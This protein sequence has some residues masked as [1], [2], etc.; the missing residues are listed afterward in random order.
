VKVLENND[1]QLSRVLHARALANEKL[2]AHAI[3]R[4]VICDQ[5]VMKSSLRRGQWVLVRNESPQ[6]FQSKWFGP[7]QIVKA[8]PLGM[9]ALREPGG[10]ELK[11]LVNGQ[12]LVKA[13]VRD[14]P[15]HL[16][17]STALNR[18][19]QD[20]GLSIEKPV[21]V[22][23]VLDETEAPPLS[24]RELSQMTKAE[25][26][27]RKHSGE[28]LGQ[29]GEG[30]LANQRRRSNKAQ[31]SGWKTAAGT[32]RPGRCIK[33]S[34]SKQEAGSKK[35]STVLDDKMWEGI[36]GNKKEKSTTQRDARELD[37]E[38][39]FAVVIPSHQEK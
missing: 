14:D 25:W 22:R 5:Q 37:F 17:T 10:Y 1:E 35:D 38:G 31:H 15:T 39:P 21:K 26:D 33:E 11:N 7:Y 23:K 8:H 19:L 12:R 30:V 28:H 36:S 16:W 24:Y 2:L 13:N 18:K 3:K 27:G 20:V 6:K 29:V 34:S 9:Y 4:K 32:G